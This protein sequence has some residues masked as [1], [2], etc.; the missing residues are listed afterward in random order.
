MTTSIKHSECVQWNVFYFSNF[1]TSMFRENLPRNCSFGGHDRSCQLGHHWTWNSVCWLFLFA[2][3][4]YLVPVIKVLLILEC[5][6][7]FFSKL[8]YCYTSLAY[9]EGIWKMAAVSGKKCIVNVTRC[10][11]FFHP[12][13]LVNETTI[14]HSFLYAVFKHINRRI[15]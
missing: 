8:R 15:A 1:S 7:S 2:K 11:A 4:S 10:L 12:S 14:H 9:S 3:R 5:W 6:S 13:N